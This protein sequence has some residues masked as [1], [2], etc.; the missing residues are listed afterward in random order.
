MV[1]KMVINTEIQIFS[2]QISLYFEK[3]KKFFLYII[4]KKLKLNFN[5]VICTKS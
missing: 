1:A 3:E 5:L 2:Y 4:E